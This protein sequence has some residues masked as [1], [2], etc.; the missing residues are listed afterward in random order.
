MAQELKP[1]GSYSNK[2]CKATPLG[3]LLI[4]LGGKKRTRFGLSE[5]WT[6]WGICNDGQAPC[7]STA[8]STT[9]PPLAAASTAMVW[10]ISGSLLRRIGTRLQRTLYRRGG[11]QHVLSRTSALSLPQGDKC[12][13]LDW[14]SIENPT[15]LKGGVL[16][17]AAAVQICASSSSWGAV[18]FPAKTL[19]V[20]KI[21][22]IDAISPDDKRV[23]GDKDCPA[24]LISIKMPRGARLGPRGSAKLG[25]HMDLRADQAE[26]N[27]ELRASK[28][29]DHNLGSS[30]DVREV[31]LLG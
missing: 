30:G 24:A 26:N 5:E 17:C 10:L 18:T 27:D 8:R 15:L 28:M 16:C 13:S 7:G 21:V 23:Q 1:P 4:P 19:Q 3:R 20:P 12:E 31:S 11:G 29:L 2:T 22:S 6:F 9:T 14:V 25:A